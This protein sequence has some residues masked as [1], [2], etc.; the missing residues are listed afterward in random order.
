MF[1]SLTVGSIYGRLLYL[2]ELPSTGCGRRGSFV[3]EC[4]NKIE[5]RLSMVGR[6]T[7]RSCGCLQRDRTASA[8]MKHGES[9]RGARTT[10]YRSWK[11]MRQRC[12]SS[13]NHAFKDYGGRGISVCDRWKDYGNFIA[14][15]GRK[16]SPAHSIERVDNEKGYGPNNCKWGTKT[17]QARNRRSNKMVD[18]NGESMS[19]AAAVERAGL[20]YARVSMRLRRGMSDQ[21]AFAL[22]DYR[23]LRL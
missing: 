20:P 15:M 3:C 18:F 22:G 1:S 7:T 19:L 2:T 6:G 4:G 11:E 13:S 9:V 14:D 10:E 23:A 21:E 5:V 8:N 17:E 12:E 16:P